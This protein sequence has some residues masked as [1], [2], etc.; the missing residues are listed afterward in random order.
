VTQA[1]AA[2]ELGVSRFRIGALLASGKLE[3]REFG[4]RRKGSLES[5]ARYAAE[6]RG[7]GRPPKVA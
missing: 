3:G 7:A 4:G 2:E 1:R 5:V 6:R